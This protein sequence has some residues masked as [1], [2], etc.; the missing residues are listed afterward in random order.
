V[1]SFF[2]PRQ[3]AMIVFMPG[4][5]VDNKWII[6]KLTEYDRELQRRRAIALG[7]ERSSIG[8]VST[9]RHALQGRGEWTSQDAIH[10]DDEKEHRE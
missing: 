10:Q 7:E 8:V 9:D 3:T 5:R 4:Y 2:T 1:F 6:F